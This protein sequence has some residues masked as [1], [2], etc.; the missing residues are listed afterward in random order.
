MKNQV[1][2][3][4]QAFK[5]TLPGDAAH[6]EMMPEI[7]KNQKFNFESRE[8][9]E[10]AVMLIIEDIYHSANIIF[11]K[12]VADNTPHSAQISFPGGKQ[13]PEDL[14]NLDTALRECEEEIGIQ[15]SELKMLGGLSPIIIP[16][17]GFRVHP[18]VSYT[19]TKLN[20]QINNN[21]VDYLIRVPLSFLL[22]ENS[23]QLV[24]LSS[25]GMVFTVPCFIFQEEIIWGATAM[26]LNEFIR[27]YQSIIK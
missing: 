23:R 26:M 12:R 11:Q 1:E 8:L 21:E 14:N 10:S 22:S 2:L 16:I 15:R 18:F 5:N 25:R 7:R 3:L 13:D 19:E 4:H 9:K 6:L 20:V 27:L 17:S 24:D